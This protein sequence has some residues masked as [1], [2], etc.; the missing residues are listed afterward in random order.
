MKC[1]VVNDGALE[2]FNEI[3]SKTTP[4]ALF[5]TNFATHILQCGPTVWNTR[6][7]H[8]RRCGLKSLPDIKYLTVRLVDLSE[9]DGLDP[10]SLD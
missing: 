2:R 9:N 10:D 3:L 7:I 6:E 1:D 8:I 5:A 4:T